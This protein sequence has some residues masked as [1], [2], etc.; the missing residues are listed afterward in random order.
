M[1]Y[2]LPHTAIIKA[3]KR[4][5]TAKEPEKKPLPFAGLGAT[6]VAS[7]PQD[8]EFYSKFLLS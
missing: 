2:N 6:K 1:I 5:A 4:E 3:K 7:D 8:Q